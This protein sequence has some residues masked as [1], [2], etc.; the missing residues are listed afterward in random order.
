MQGFCSIITAGHLPYAR[1]MFAS[2]CKYHPGAVL[3]L[4]VTDGEAKPPEQNIVTYALHHLLHLDG[5]ADTW[6]RYGDNQPD[7]LRWALKPVF[8]NWLLEKFEKIVYADVD[9]FFTGNLDFVFDSLS[10]HSV[11]LTPHWGSLSP[12][13]HT[14]D[15]ELNFQIGLYNAGFVAA[16][17]KGRKTLRWWAEAC[18]FK[19]TKDIA[20]GYFDDQR[21]LDLLPVVDE[22]A[23][24][25]RHPGCNVAGWNIHQCKRSLA[26]GRM[27]INGQYPVVFI[28][29]NLSTLLQI[30]YGRDPL[31]ADYLSAYK[32]L[33][34]S[35][36]YDFDA[37]QPGFENIQPATA[38]SIKRKLRVRTRLKALVLRLYQR[39]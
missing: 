39:L 25:I 29:F 21:Y 24:V 18:R 9:L 28:H 6:S 36:G 34:K 19:M 32:E 37:V 12:L 2:V 13:P 35:L 30:S 22:R 26:N 17:R 16:S 14:T 8:M 3:H 4:L 7:A 10:S 31:L 1:V 38:V 20:S 11:L 5:F 23:G 15:F 27:V 33:F